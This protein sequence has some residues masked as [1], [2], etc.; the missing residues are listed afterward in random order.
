MDRLDW[1]FMRWT[2]HWIH[3]RLTRLLLKA[4][5]WR[6]GEKIAE[7]YMWEMTPFPAGLPFPSQYLEGLW[8]VVCGP[9]YFGAILKRSYDQFDR[10]WKWWKEIEKRERQA[11]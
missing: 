8:L 10:E 6:C 1:F 4:I 9:R 11:A 2:P 3:R 7:E 5:T